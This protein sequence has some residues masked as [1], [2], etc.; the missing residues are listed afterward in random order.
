MRRNWRWALIGVGVCAVLFGGG[1]TAE[2]YAGGK[3]IGIIRLVDVDGRPVEAQTAAQF[4]RMR[5]AAAAQGVALRVSSGFRTWAQQLQLY[6]R[7]L[8]G[9]DQ[10]AKPGWSNHQNGVALDIEVGRSFTSKAYLWLAANAARYGFKNTGA[11]FKQPEPW[12]W[13]RVAVV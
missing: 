9:G 2:A 10:A 12:H 3:V 5:A 6:A 4:L 1:S 13:E 7:Y 8:A 11:T